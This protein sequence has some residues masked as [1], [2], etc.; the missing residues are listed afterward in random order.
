M[1]VEQNV[2]LN[3]KTVTINQSGFIT[4]TDEDFVRFWQD[5]AGQWKIISTGP[6]VLI[7]ERSPSG[8]GARGGRVLMSG[9]IQG[10][11]WL[12]DI[13]GFISN[14]RWTGTLTAASGGSKRQ[15]FFDK[16]TLRLAAS[17][18]RS[19][20]LGEIMFRENLITRA[21]LDEALSQVT[22][23]RRI[24]EIL[25]RQGLCGTS[26]IFRMIYRQVEEIFFSTLLMESG[27]FYFT[28][29]LE[30][31]SL[32]A[33]LSLDTSALLLEAVKRIDEIS[34][35]KKRIPGINIVLKRRI[36]SFPPGMPALDGEFLARCDGVRT[37]S[38]IAR[39]I[40]IPD[41]DAMK[42]AY[43]FLDS[44]EVEVVLTE[45]TYEESV[46]YAVS[47]FNAIIDMIHAEVEEE[48]SRL[49]LFMVEKNYLRNAQK[50]GEIPAGICLDDRGRFDEASVKGALGQLKGTNKPSA[51]IQILTQY[52]FFVLFTAS[53]YL[54]RQRQQQL[55][56]KV[57]SLI[58]KVT[59]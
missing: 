2:R 4:E 51:L 28:E 50:E 55:N 16:G 5:Q 29:G 14:S 15:L 31:L 43:R 49:N 30:P 3:G 13:V 10:E 48:E 17:S 36:R 33:I 44:G 22:G 39:E 41:F 25:I 47:H 37:L 53:T 18:L 21:Q 11:G 1:A 6:G 57:H 27:W 52:T 19:E 24:G 54:P 46:R 23:D 32:P 40:S 56:M 26:D 38:Q 34:Y 45:T 59:S 58:Q 8:E 42:L 20:H 7:L 12:T 35:F 9:E